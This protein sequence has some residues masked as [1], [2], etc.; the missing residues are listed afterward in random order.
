[1]QQHDAPFRSRP[2]TR[3]VFPSCAPRIF[4]L[5]SAQQ[6][7]SVFVANQRHHAPAFYC[8]IAALLPP[9]AGKVADID[10]AVS[11]RNEAV[12]AA[13]RSV[14][15]SS[16]S[17]AAPA[18]ASESVAGAAEEEAE[19][20]PAPWS[21]REDT[22]GPDPTLWTLASGQET[23]GVAERLESWGGVRG[24]R[25]GVSGDDVTTGAGYIVGGSES[26]LDS[27]SAAERRE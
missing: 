7:R 6:R 10:E 3:A 21:P 24:G 18:S 9:R 23:A 17:T 14:T 22:D 16:A 4:V 1:M 15:P 12:T 25:T 13:S 5:A 27:D 20:S 26:R 2:C 19:A 11:L 8:I